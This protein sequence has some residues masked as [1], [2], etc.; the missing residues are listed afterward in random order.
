MADDPAQVTD[1]VTAGVG[2]GAWVDLVEHSGLPPRVGVVHDG[3]LSTSAT[4]RSM[5]VPRYATFR[6]KELRC[7]RSR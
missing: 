6:A 1:P 7:H 3:E 5:L 2:E 4:C